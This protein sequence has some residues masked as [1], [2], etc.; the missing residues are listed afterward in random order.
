VETFLDNVTIVK[1]DEVGDI[2]NGH[3]FYY[4]EIYYI[5]GH[6]IINWGNT[7]VLTKLTT[8][9]WTI[10]PR[11]QLLYWRGR[12]RFV[13]NHEFCMVLHTGIAPD[14]PICTLTPNL[15]LHSSFSVLSAPGMTEYRNGDV[16]HLQH[17]DR[18]PFLLPKYEPVSFATLQAAMPQHTK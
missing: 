1:S 8:G 10:T 9:M 16:F 14:E 7:D 5:E 15:D 11:P 6:R 12:F 18:P 4:N 17:A 3:Q 13:R 2:K